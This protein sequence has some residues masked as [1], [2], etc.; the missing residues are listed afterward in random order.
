MTPHAPD[1]PYA[2]PLSQGG[3][4]AVAVIPMTAYL[5]RL[6]GNWVG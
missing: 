1:D 4:I 6:A 5:A 2:L 3:E